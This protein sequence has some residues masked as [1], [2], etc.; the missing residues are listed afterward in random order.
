MATQLLFPPANQPPNHLAYV[1]WFT[2]FSATPDPRHSMYKVTRFIWSGER[3]ASIIPVSNISCS[4]HLIP[5]FR[6]IVP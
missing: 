5:K 1:E 6:A 3:V 4:V 2:P